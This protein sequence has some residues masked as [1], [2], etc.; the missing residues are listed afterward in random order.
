MD[1]SKH[2]RKEKHSLKFKQDCQLLL[3]ICYC[4]FISA[5]PELFFLI[6]NSGRSEVINEWMEILN[7]L[8]VAREDIHLKTVS[9]FESLKSNDTRII[10]LLL[11]GA[12]QT[13]VNQVR[14]WCNS[15]RI[16]SCNMGG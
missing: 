10:Q 6:K 12:I 2:N 16:S 1:Q 7:P 8:Q 5:D 14:F 13:Q 15:K 9:L 4:Y 3:V 11:Q